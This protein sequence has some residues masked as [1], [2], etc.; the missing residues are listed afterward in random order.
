MFRRHSDRESIRFYGVRI[1]SFVSAFYTNEDVHKAGEQDVKQCFCRHCTNRFVGRERVVLVIMTFPTYKWKWFT[2]YDEI[3]LVVYWFI[4]NEIT[5]SNQAESTEL[6]SNSRSTL[7]SL[8]YILWQGHPETSVG[9]SLDFILQ[10]L[11][12]HSSQRM[13]RFRTECDNSFTISQLVS[14]WTLQTLN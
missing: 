12:H 9:G 7:S 8:L 1:S 11:S 13:L 6:S 5:T 4:I 10:S 14:M 3:A 2:I